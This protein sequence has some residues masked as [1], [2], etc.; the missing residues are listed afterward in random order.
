MSLVHL[1]LSVV[2]P[3]QFLMVTRGY[4]NDFFIV[5]VHTFS[6]VI[7]SFQDEITKEKV[8]TFTMKKTFYTRESSTDAQLR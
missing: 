8:C 4:N 5:K 3:N 1:L 2:L 6:L 7:S